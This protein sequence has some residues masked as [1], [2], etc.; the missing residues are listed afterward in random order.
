MSS[1]L[2]TPLTTVCVMHASHGVSGPIAYG[3][4]GSLIRALANTHTHTHTHTVFG[5]RPPRPRTKR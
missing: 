5:H 4:F 2:S 3:Y 1:P